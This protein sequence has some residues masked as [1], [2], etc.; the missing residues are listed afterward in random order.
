MEEFRDRHLWDH[1]VAHGR[2]AVSQRYPGEHHEGLSVQSSPCTPTPQAAGV[3]GRTLTG[4]VGAEQAMDIALI[5]EGTYPYVHGGVSTWCDKLVRGLTEHRFH[6]VSLVAFG[7]ETRG[8]ELP[9]NVASLRAVP[10]WGP[11]T[12]PRRTRNQPAVA[13]AARTLI[14]GSVRG[15]PDLFEWGLTQLAL[16]AVEIDLPAALRACDLVSDLLD[17]WPDGGSGLTVRDAITVVG[18]LERSLLPLAVDLDFRPDLCHAVSN[19]LPTMVGLAEKW[20]YGTPLVMSEHGVYLRERYLAFR[21][22]NYSQGVR[23]AFLGFLRQLTQVGYRHA[24]F[25][26]PVAQFNAR[27]AQRLGADPETILPI[28]NG[29]DPESYP[30][31]TTEPAVPTISWVGRVDP[32]KDLETLISAYAKVRAQM[33]DAV[34]RL[35]GPTPEGN[36]AY[37]ARCLALADRLGVRSGVR[38][39]GPVPSSRVA[40][41]AGHVVAL[42]S[43]SEGMPYTVIE[44]MMCGRATVSTDVGGTADAVGDAGIV[45]APRDPEAF[46]E[47]CLAL[48]TDHPRRRELGRAARSRALSTFTLERSIECYRSLYSSVMPTAE[49]LMS[50]DFS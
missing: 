9:A 27:W 36:Q 41:E 11:A 1:P 12:R 42:S 39:E 10:L 40:S 19:G 26:V 47:A 7:N 49:L 3:H 32:L 17:A 28:Y 2:Q 38:L 35:F 44:A 8:W 43:I 46:A 34:L 18:L 6:L 37:E 13:R 30:E 21:D 33:P 20:R 45:V 5:N 4:R 24:D 23:Q 50:G 31:I 14:Q 48:L 16:L 22:L 25:V 15:D 29:V